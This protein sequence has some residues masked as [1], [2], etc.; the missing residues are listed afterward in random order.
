MSQSQDSVPI[1]TLSNWYA[2]EQRA[3]NAI[4]NFCEAGKAVI[5][6]TPYVLMAPCQSPTIQYRQ[7]RWNDKDPHC[8]KTMVWCHGLVHARPSSRQV[9]RSEIKVSS[10]TTKPLVISHHSS[11]RRCRKSCQSPPWLRTSVPG[12]RHW[13]LVDH[14]SSMCH[15]ARKLSTCPN[16]K[17]MGEFQTI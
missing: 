8:R 17:S 15:C 4:A 7:H 10:S 11:W 13:P 6:N 14:P 5:N 2:W 3:V 12:L 9:Q 1:L 16:S